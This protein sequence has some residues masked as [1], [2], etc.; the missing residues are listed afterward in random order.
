M[1]SALRAIALAAVV[2]QLR[3]VGGDGVLCIDTVTTSGTVENTGT[4]NLL[5]FLTPRN[6]VDP[7]IR[8][9]NNPV[10]GHRTT[11]AT[12]LQFVV[13]TAATSPTTPIEW[14]LLNT[15]GYDL[16]FETN[17]CSPVVVDGRA[18]KGAGGRCTASDTCGVTNAVAANYTFAVKVP[19]QTVAT[20][21]LYCSTQDDN[22][23][24]GA[25]A[26]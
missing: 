20:W 9:V 25:A 24:R 14:Y 6:S 12:T 16:C 15:T 10:P 2:M 17:V 7:F 4:S 19:P 13:T 26:T 23:A 21:A 1:T 18:I 8:I 5:R 22:S 11:A 3:P